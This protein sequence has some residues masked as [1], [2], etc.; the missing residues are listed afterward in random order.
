VIALTGVQ[1]A[2]AAGAAAPVVGPT[3][4]GVVAFGNV[5]AVGSNRTVALTGVQAQ[6]LAGTPNY[7]YWTTIDDSQTPSWQNVDNSQASGWVDVEM[8]V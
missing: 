1:A 8:V 4:D 3:E 2:G 6:G 7:F 5:G